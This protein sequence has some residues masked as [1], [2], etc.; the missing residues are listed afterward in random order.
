MATQT[1]RTTS[2]TSGPAPPGSPHIRDLSSLRN[3]E[4]GSAFRGISRARGGRS[5]RGGR[6]GGRPSSTLGSAVKE[7]RLEGRLLSDTVAPQ[8]EALAKG[9]ASMLVLDKPIGRP[10]RGAKSKPPS[11]RTSRVTP[12]LVI[13][14]P[15]SETSPVMPS[16]SRSSNRNRRSH[17][18]SKAPSDRN[19]RPPSSQPPLKLPRARNGSTHPPAAIRKDIPPHLVA[20]HEA[21]VR[22]DIE[23]LVERVRAVAMAENRPTTPG[24]H[25]D[26]AGEEDDSLPDLD[27]WGVTTTSNTVNGERNEGISPILADALKQLPEPRLD[28]EREV[29]Y[30]QDMETYSDAD[31]EANEEFNDPVSTHLS[32]DPVQTDNLTTPISEQSPDVSTSE[33]FPQSPSVPL[34]T[35]TKSPEHLPLLPQTEGS[36]DE[37][38]DPPLKSSE[39]S[40]DDDLISTCEGISESIHT[41]SSRELAAIEPRSRSSDERS[42]SASIHAPARHLESRS[43]SSLLPDQTASVKNSRS[44]GRSHTETRPSQA[45]RSSRSGA[46]SPLGQ[47]VYTHSRNHSSPPTGGPSH[48][49]HHTSRPVITGE[50]ISRLARTIGGLGQV[51][52]TQGIQL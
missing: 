4:S 40:T 6:G 37:A 28:I 27:D 29:S 14:P 7:E 8:T 25:I 20:S 5:N 51:S 47:H 50:A 1:S 41:P 24:S 13:A 16:N 2:S 30:H 38:V 52:R 21:E 33:V 31:A 44:H 10:E 18:Q 39:S 12:T 34:A 26:W 3:G 17:Q 48:R 43:A 11:R 9:P 46:S 36:I 22:H 23:A 15:P 42:L 35:D 19:L 49:T 32:T 45:P